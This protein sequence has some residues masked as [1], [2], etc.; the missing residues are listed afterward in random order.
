MYFLYTK[1]VKTLFCFDKKLL[2]QY[3]E[4]IMLQFVDF[5]ISHKSVTECLNELKYANN[6]FCQRQFGRK[7]QCD[8][9]S[10]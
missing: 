6:V 9:G 7:A 10:K 5:G 4:E 1:T 2:C 3:L 8:I